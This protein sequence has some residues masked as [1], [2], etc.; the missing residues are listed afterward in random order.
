MRGKHANDGI[1][2]TKKDV[3]LD[4]VEHGVVG[5]NVLDE[6]FVGLNGGGPFLRERGVGRGSEEGEEGN[7]AIFEPLDAHGVLPQ[8][9]VAFDVEVMKDVHVGGGG[10]GGVSKEGQIGQDVEGRAVHLGLDESCG[11]ALR[12]MDEER[13]MEGEGIV[14]K[15]FGVQIGKVGEI[16]L[17]EP[18][19]GHGRRGS[20]G[21]LEVAFEVERRERNGEDKVGEKRKIV[22]LEEGRAVEAD[23]PRVFASPKGV[24]VNEEEKAE[25]IGEIEGEGKF[26]PFQ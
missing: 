13:G 24:M 25:R 6:S 22:F 12:Q 7:G 10:G 2:L 1:G 4:A 15:A 11:E 16:V 18:Q 3:S 26:G 23:E 5:L 19:L 21:L 8:G 9:V 14:K 17:S 20:A